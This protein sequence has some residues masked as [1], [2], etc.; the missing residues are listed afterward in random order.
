MVRS[1]S[2][3]AADSDQTDITSLP[4]FDGSQLAMAQWL[5]DLESAQHLFDSDVTYFLR[6]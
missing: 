2:Q 4:V 3:Q 6:W 5:R 1:N